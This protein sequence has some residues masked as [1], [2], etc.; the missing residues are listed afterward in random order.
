MNVLMQDNNEIPIVVQNVH[1]I[2]FE[3]RQINAYA[4]M[5]AHKLIIILTI[6]G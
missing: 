4:V 1:E 5:N 3:R 2:N 6:S